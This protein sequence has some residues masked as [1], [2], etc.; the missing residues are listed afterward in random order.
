MSMGKAW[1][2]A[3]DHSTR[4]VAARFC[5]TEIP[6]YHES[7]CFASLYPAAFSCQLEVVPFGVDEH[8]GH[9]IGCIIPHADTLESAQAFTF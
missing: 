6:N 2:K 1:S 7:F 4:E 3:W 8:L 9:L 5:Y